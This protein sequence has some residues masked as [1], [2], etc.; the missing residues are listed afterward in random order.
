MGCFLDEAF[1]ELCA[2]G[3]IEGL[4]P[5]PLGVLHLPQVECGELQRVF[6]S[7]RS[8]VGDFS[9]R[10]DLCPEDQTHGFQFGL[11]R[12]DEPIFLIEVGLC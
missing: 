2:A 8:E 6:I 10:L 1:H 4:A 9:E 7:V 3:D 12:D 11:A 5:N